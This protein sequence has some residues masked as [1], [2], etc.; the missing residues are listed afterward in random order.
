M[1]GPSIEVI[2]QNLTE[3]KDKQERLMEYSLMDSYDYAVK[4]M[5]SDGMGRVASIE[6]ALRWYLRELEAKD[7]KD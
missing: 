4:G 5:L 1:S 7:V 3:D 2:I 6:T